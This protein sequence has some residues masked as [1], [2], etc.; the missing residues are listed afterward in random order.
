MKQS[1]QK[2]LDELEKRVRELEGMVYQ[3][4]RSCYPYLAVLPPYR[5]YWYHYPILY[6]GN[7]TITTGTTTGSTTATQA[8]QNVT[9]T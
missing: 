8:P 4:D 9:Y 3:G 7:Q 2:R 1:L 6:D 5:P